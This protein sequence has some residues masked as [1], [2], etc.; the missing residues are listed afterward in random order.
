MSNA[1]VWFDLDLD[2]MEDE[3]L[4]VLLREADFRPARCALQR[5]HAEGGRISSKVLQD[6]FG[7]TC[8]KKT[9]KT[10]GK[11][12]HFGRTRRLILTTSL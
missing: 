10:R 8:A 1:G 12:P 4:V 11:R 5:K 9:S 6:D 7:R 2:A 3:A